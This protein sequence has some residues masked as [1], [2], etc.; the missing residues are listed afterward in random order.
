MALSYFVV[1]QAQDE[2]VH[3]GEALAVLGEDL[4]GDLGDGK[5]GVD[6]G[7]QFEAGTCVMEADGQEAVGAKGRH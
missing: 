4:G 3:Q 5:R 2:L 6:D 1:H 7:D